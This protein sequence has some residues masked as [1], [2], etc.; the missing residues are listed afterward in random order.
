MDEKGLK[1]EFHKLVKDIIKYYEL[2]WE[3]FKLEF[4]ESLAQLYTKVFSIFLLWIIVP[5]FLLF[6]LIA[7]A[8]Y[9]G[10][11]WGELYLGFLAVGGG[12]LVLGAIILAFRKVLITNP[13]VDALVSAMF[14]L[15]NQNEIKISKNAKTSQKNKDSK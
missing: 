10:K 15:D 13:L 1:E 6:L 12:V 11:I 7:L 3:Y 9:L 14:D 2:K 4:V 5:L 8:L